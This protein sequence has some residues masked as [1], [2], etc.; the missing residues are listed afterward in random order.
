MCECF[1]YMPVSAL[2]VC[3]VPAEA[4]RGHQI[5]WSGSHRVFYFCFLFFK[6]WGMGTELGSSGKASSTLQP[7]E[8]FEMQII[9]R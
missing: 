7:L 1:T 6:H 2:N 4:R 8:Q 5:P 9:K 3:L